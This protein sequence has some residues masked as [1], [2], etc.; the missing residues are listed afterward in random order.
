MNI[1]ITGAAKRVGAACVRLLHNEGHNIFLHYRQSAQDAEYIAAEL[2]AI[3]PD[4]V[5]IMGADLLHVAGIRSLA[6]KAQAAWGGIDVLINNASAFYATEVSSVTEQQWDELFGS[7]VKAAFFLTQAL[8]ANLA[9]RQGLIVNIVDIHA[10]RGLKGYSVYSIAKAGLAA[11]TR[12]LARELGP[13]IRVNAVAPGA[14]LWPEHAMSEVEKQEI[15]QRI[16]LGR[17]GAPDDIAK[18]VRYLIQDA[19][20]VTGQIITVDG[21][22]TLYC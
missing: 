16:A 11:M 4:S 18:A 19:G 13:S 21:G 3:R 17:S 5:R 2:N 6:E 7:N 1:L 9:E 15:T 8:S 12:I 14:I 22:R 20:Y 10:E